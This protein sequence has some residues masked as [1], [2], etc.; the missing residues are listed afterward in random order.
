[1]TISIKHIVQGVAALLL[2]SMLAGCGGGGSATVGGTVGGLVTGA[3]VTLQNNNTD[4]LTIAADQGFT[5]P[6]TLTTGSDYSVTVV[7]QP[8]GEN[9]AVGNASGVIDS[10]ADNV[11]NVT[12][13]CSVTSSIGGTV[14]GLAVG[15]SVWLSSNGQLLPIATNGAF[16]FPGVLAAGSNFNVTVSAQPAQQTCVVANGSGVVSTSAMATVFVNCS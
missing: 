10:T 2:A 7:T 12:V 16:A 3:S 14:T 8:V 4:T 9:C 15:N 1:M 11:A 13:T 6:A 5:F